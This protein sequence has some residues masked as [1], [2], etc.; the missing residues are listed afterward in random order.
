MFLWNA[1]SHK[2]IHT[3]A[4]ARHVC[5]IGRAKKYLFSTLKCSQLNSLH[6][7]YLQTCFLTIFNVT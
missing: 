3:G 1:K 5:E 6:V 2:N 7:L 4:L